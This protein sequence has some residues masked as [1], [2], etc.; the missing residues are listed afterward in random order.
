MTIYNGPVPTVSYSVEGGSPHLQALCQT[1][2]FTENEINL[3]KELQD[4]RLGIVANER[5]LDTLRTAQQLSLGPISPPGYAACYAPPD[6]ALKCA[7]IPGLAREA[8]PAMAYELIN[9]WE[10]VQT[11]LQAEQNQAVAAVRGG[12]P[13][14]QNAQPVATVAAP[15][16]LQQPETPV[17]APQAVAQQLPMPLVTFTDP[18]QASAFQQMVRQNQERARQQLMQMQQQIIQPHQ[19]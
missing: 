5:T 7:L 4:L 13:A 17:A 19:L 2:E 14:R 12:P 11:Q 15:A 18:Q 9:L 16:A 6:S 10:Q 3:T 1:L 8:T